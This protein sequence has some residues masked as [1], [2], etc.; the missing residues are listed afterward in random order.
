MVTN[1]FASRGA[2]LFLLFFLIILP[3]SQSGMTQ[4]LSLCMIS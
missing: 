3:S 4:N 2:W 1:I